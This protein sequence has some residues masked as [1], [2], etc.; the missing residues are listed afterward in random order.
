MTG[1]MTYLQ[2]GFSPSTS[3]ITPQRMERA[4]TRPEAMLDAKLW[5]LQVPSCWSHTIWSIW[6]FEQFGFQ[7]FP[8]FWHPDCGSNFDP[9]IGGSTR[10]S[11]RGAIKEGSF[12][13]SQFRVCAIANCNI[14]IQSCR[15]ACARCFQESLFG[16]TKHGIRRNSTNKLNHN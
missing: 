7:D 2:K 13:G 9:Q 4:S 12:E 5:Q 1:V 15:K 10:G 3:L 14:V 6:C 16:G 11:T 8:N